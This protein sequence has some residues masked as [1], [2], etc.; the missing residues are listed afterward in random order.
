MIQKQVL[1]WSLSIF[2][3]SAIS[4]PF[5]LASSKVF[6]LDKFLSI[7]RVSDPTRIVYIGVSI[8]IA[9]IGFLLWTQRQ[10]DY[11]NFQVDRIISSI[12]LLFGPA[13]LFFFS[14]KW[15]SSLG[16][17]KN[18][19]AGDDWVTYQKLA[20]EVVVNGEW[21][22]AG[23]TVFTMQPLYRYIIGIYHWLFGQ[24][25]F[26]QNM[27]DVWCVLGATVLI[28]RF[29]IKFR[30]SPLMIFI[31]SIS[32]LSINLLGAFKHFIPP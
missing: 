3:V 5:I 10:K 29:A 24:S 15:W 7:I 31:T 12:F 23:E 26:V 28:A 13:L 21:L 30:I 32:Y 16:Q 9:G 19:G 22:N 4:I 11:R 6:L 8:I 14:N 2:S 27:S 1:N 25:A 17:W 20:R 18:W